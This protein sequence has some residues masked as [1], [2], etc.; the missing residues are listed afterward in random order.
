MFPWDSEIVWDDDDDPDGN[1][2]HIAEHDLTPDEVE[3]VLTNPV[4]RTILSRSSGRPMTRGETY[5][6][7]FIVVVWER[8]CDDPDL[9]RP[10]TAYEP[11]PQ[12]GGT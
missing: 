11:D 8:L 7:R 1:V 4:N 6:G 9:I 5:T 12:F 10:V 3:S 2:R